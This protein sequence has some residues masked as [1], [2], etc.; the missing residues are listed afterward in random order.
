MLY[1][2]NTLSDMVR[3][4]KELLTTIKEKDREGI[5]LKQCECLK[6]KALFRYALARNVG[7]KLKGE[8]KGQAISEIEKAVDWLAN[9]GGTMIIPIWQIL[10]NQR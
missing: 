8:E 1:R 2:L 6:W 3:Q 7:K 5:D 9:H 4:E 10:Y